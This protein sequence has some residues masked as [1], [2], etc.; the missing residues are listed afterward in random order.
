MTKVSSG[1]VKSGPPAHAN[2]HAFV[3]NRKSLLTAKILASPISGHLCPG[4]HDVLEWRKRYRKY[5]PLT[6]AKKCT[7][8]QQKTIKEAYHV[9][10]PNCSRDAQCCPKCLEKHKV[11]VPEKTSETKVKVAE[12]EEDTAGESEDFEEVDTADDSEEDFE[13]EDSEKEE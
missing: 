5:K 10:C 11:G 8:C 7:R 1:A 6:V 4:C 12:L 2:R 3:H 9:I 13:E